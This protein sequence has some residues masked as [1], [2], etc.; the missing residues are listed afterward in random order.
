MIWYYFEELMQHNLFKWIKPKC[1][2]IPYEKYIMFEVLM[3]E[4]TN[5]LNWENSDNKIVIWI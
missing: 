3:D 2:I 5:I 4:F 1:I